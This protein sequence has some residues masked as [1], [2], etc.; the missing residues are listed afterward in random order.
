MKESA[1]PLGGRALR[2][3]GLPPNSDAPFAGGSTFVT[4][5]LAAETRAKHRREAIKRARAK[6]KGRL[7]RGGDA[8]PAALIYA[9]RLGVA[10][11]DLGRLAIAL[12]AIGTSDAFDA[13][14]GA[15]YDDLDAVFMRL[16]DE[17]A[18]Q[19]AFKLPM[20]DDV[21]ELDDELREPVLAASRAQAA[22]WL[23]QWTSCAGGWPLLRRLA[24]GM[25]HGSP[26]IPR[27]TTLT[28]P[29][30]G[31][32]GRHA[33]D[34]FERWVL[35]INTDED[36]AAVSISTQ[37]TVADISDSTLALAHRAVLD[38]VALA[39]K[40]AAAHMGRVNSGYKFVLSRD[41]VRTLPPEQR[42]TIERHLNA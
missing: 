28:P 30:A 9:Q 21:A 13:L 14:R 4:Y 2:V 24:K 11:E 5:C 37:W 17:P 26:L 15:T 39:R 29:G 40:L 18:L 7:R 23:S 25:R 16:R 8:Y 35:V 31:D 6:Y 3:S 41:I 20:D 42:K 34:R 38:G 1:K 12:E 22:R 32:L 33:K 36:A 19:R 10:I 27:E